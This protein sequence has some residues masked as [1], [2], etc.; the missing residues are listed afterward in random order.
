MTPPGRRAMNQANVRRKFGD[1]QLPGAAVD[2]GDAVGAVV[3]AAVVVDP[4][5]EL[6]EPPGGGAVGQHLVDP[7]ALGTGGAESQ[8]GEQ[9]V[10]I[11]WLKL[12]QDGDGSGGGFADAPGGRDSG[13]VALAFER[14]AG[15]RPPVGGPVGVTLH[16][17]RAASQVLDLGV[18]GP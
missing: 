1:F 4:G 3:A 5:S 2:C 17:Y 11:R 18:S 14:E 16:G 9:Q 7:A 8:V 13:R 12:F 15:H 10:D 6:V